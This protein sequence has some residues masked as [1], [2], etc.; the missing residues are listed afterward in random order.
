MATLTNGR[1]NTEALLERAELDGYVEQVL[2]TE[3]VPA[4]K[5]HPTPYRHAPVSE[6]PSAADLLEAADSLIAQPA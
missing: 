1:E 3:A 6:A 2:T 4:Y 5:P